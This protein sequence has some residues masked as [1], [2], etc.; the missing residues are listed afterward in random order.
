MQAF[1][2]PFFF[3]HIRKQE[4]YLILKRIFINGYKILGTYFISIFFLLVLN[5]SLIIANF[6]QI[7]L[8]YYILP[9]LY[10]SIS[11]L[12]V[13]SVFVSSYIVSVF[14]EIMFSEISGFGDFWQFQV[15]MIVGNFNEKGHFLFLSTNS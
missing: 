5:L 3:Y 7:N 6:D 14:K 1:P 4:L 2:P 10:F 13:L 8:S 9:L 11:Y 15:L 12:F